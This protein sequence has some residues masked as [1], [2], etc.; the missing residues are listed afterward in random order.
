MK[1]D[2]LSPSGAYRSHSRINKLLN[3][4]SK[5]TF[6]EKS[7]CSSATTAFTVV[8]YKKEK[9][10]RKDKQLGKRRSQEDLCK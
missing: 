10:A 7:Y 5:Q 2:V 1:V 6:P 3:A 4:G 9:K 8:D